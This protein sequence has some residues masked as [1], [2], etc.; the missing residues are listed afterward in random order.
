MCVLRAERFG[1]R[2]TTRLRAV[3]TVGVLILS[4]AFCLTIMQRLPSTLSC[5]SLAYW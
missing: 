3:T 5:L 4:E 1:S 2:R